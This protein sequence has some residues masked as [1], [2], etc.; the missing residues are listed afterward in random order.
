MKALWFIACLFAGE[1]FAK[2]NQNAVVIGLGEAYSPDT[3]RLTISDLD[4]MFSRS[5]ELSFGQRFW[6]GPAYLGIGL[7]SKGGLYG[8]MGVQGVVLE[9]ALLVFFEFQGAGGYRGDVHAFGVFGGG[10]HW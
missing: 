8:L 5:A 2:A 3:F 1:A 7:S 6:S 10:F 4:F 9:S